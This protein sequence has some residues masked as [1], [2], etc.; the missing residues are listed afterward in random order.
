MNI[1]DTSRAITE[2]TVKWLPP[3][4]KLPGFLTIN[5]RNMKLLKMNSSLL[6]KM[7][8]KISKLG[9]FLITNVNYSL[10]A[11]KTKNQI[12]VKICQTF[13]LYLALFKCL[14]I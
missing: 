2:H 10:T 1:L 12:K 8:L 7:C 4:P 14:G 6:S 9:L 11:F 3:N 13:D 5:M